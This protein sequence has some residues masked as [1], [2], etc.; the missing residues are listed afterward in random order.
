VYRTFF[1]TPSG[2][3]LLYEHDDK[4]RVTPKIFPYFL[5]TLSSV[6]LP[7]DESHNLTNWQRHPTQLENQEIQAEKSEK[8][9]RERRLEWL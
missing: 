6:V 2:R 8:L 1:F 4:V 3:Y 9:A 5:P 7:G